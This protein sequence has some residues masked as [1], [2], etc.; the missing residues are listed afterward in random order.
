M[1]EK[2]CCEGI[3]S[4]DLS[5]FRSNAGDK[6]TSRVDKEK[7]LNEIFKNKYNLNGRNT[8]FIVFFFS[9]SNITFFSC[10]SVLFLFSLVGCSAF[11]Q[12]SHCASGFLT[13]TGGGNSS[14]DEIISVS[15]P[16]LD[17]LLASSE[18]W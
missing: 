18:S 8:L 10:L 7:K 3:Q 16:S 1:R 13:L 14:K 4:E 11:D 6:K 5:K 12:F 17:K 15:L 9:R 2:T